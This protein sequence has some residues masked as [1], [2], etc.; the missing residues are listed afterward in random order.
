MTLVSG[1]RM[2]QAEHYRRVWHARTFF[3]EKAQPWDKRGEVYIRYGEPDYRSRSGGANAH[4]PPAAYAVKERI[5]AWLYGDSDIGDGIGPIFPVGTWQPGVG[6]SW[7]SWVYTK[8]GGG[9]ELVLTDEFGNGRWDF[10]PMP[11]MNDRDRYLARKLSRMTEFLPAAV[12]QDVASRTPD[13]YDLP[14]GIDPLAFYYDVATF[15]GSEGRT[16]VE[17]YVGIPP[18]QMLVQDVT[19]GAFGLPQGML[20]VKAGQERGWV[21][22][23][24]TVAL[25]DAEGS[26][27]GR[28]QDELAFAIPMA[29]TAK[30]G[31][32]VPDVIALDVPPGEYRLA[33]RVSD[34]ASGK[35]GVYLQDL[36]APDYRD[37]LAMSDLE[38]A[39][40][41]SP[42]PQAE[43]FHKGEVY[44]VPMPSRS[45]RQAQGVYVY[46]EVYNLQR[47]DFGQTRYRVEYAV[48]RHARRKGGTTLVSA[49]GVAFDWLFADKKPEVVISY[50]RAGTEASEP[51]YLELDTK[52]LKPGLNQIEVRVTDLKRN[53][54][55][56]R[57][58]VFRLSDSKE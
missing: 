42:G 46:Y 30:R 29:D 20:G 49:V 43:K 5:A 28:S 31:A 55:V 18:E 15:R 33:V 35:W 38:M 52:K 58:A 11:K 48:R 32:F 27:V 10:A 37:A 19:E 26:E 21:Q 1:G 39:W 13:Y 50:E 9:I 41:V 16:Q 56:S 53:K 40:T 45:Y 6:V 14:P 36:K 7:E 25:A 47:D 12:M 8:I 51:I 57:K 2:R 17:V 4:P 34:R 44:V 23:G 22:V 54:T 3:S 24:R